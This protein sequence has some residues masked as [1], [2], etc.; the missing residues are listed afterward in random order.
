MGTAATLARVGA[1]DRTL[2]LAAE[3]TAGRGRAG[4]TWQSP[5]KTGVFCTAVLR[6]DVPPRR[7]STLPLLTGVAVAE[8]IEQLCGTRVLLKWP[9][10]VWIGDDPRRH[11]VAGI[12]ATSSLLGDRVDHV[13]IGIGINVSTKPDKLPPG[14]T[15]INATTGLA[16]TPADVLAVLLERLDGAYA[17]YLA[18]GG[19]PSLDAWRSRAALLGEC[20]TV[21]EAGRAQNGKFAGVDDDGA[22]ILRTAAGAVLRFVAGDLVRGPSATH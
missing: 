15:S 11:K 5:P 9:N 13:L 8:T 6:P 18:A 12:L 4:R 3:Q 2:V 17:D 7:L 20:I 19:Q 10:D 21:E 14:A 1:R 22:L 16:V